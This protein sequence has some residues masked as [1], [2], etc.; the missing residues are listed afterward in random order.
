[1]TDSPSFNA[2][3]ISVSESEFYALF[4]DKVASQ[5][6]KLLT[7]TPKSN[8]DLL[9]NYLPSKLWRL[10]NLY[11]I[12]N[13]DGQHRKFHMNRAQFVV[14]SKL[15]LHH[16][17]IILKSRQQGISTL[18]LISFEDD[19]I[20]RSNLNCGL[21]AQGREEAQTLL[22]RVK[23]TWD[24]L[25]PGIK[26][27]V[28]VKLDKDNASEFS[29]SNNST[30]FIRTSFRSATL[31]RLHISELGKIANESPKKAKETKTGTLQTLAP[32]NLG[33]IESTA[34]GNNMFK[35][36]WDGAEK[37]LAVGRLA[38]KDFYPIF[39][40]WLDD[41]DCVEYEDQIPTSD[42]FD[43]FEKL[44]KDLS[45]VVT[46][47]QR[48]FWIAQER[49]LEGDIHQEYPATAKEAFAAAK[50]GT[51]WARLYLSHVIR[52][53]KKLPNIYD[54]NLPVYCVMDLGRNDL[55]V[56][57]FFQLWESIEGDISI[58]IIKSYWNSGEGLDHY[59]DKLFEFKAE[60]N[61]SMPAPIGLPHDASVTDLST[62]GQRSR[63]D[64]LHEYGVTNTVI[65]A[66]QPKEAGIEDVRKEIPY[67]ILDDR[68]TYIEDCFLNYTKVWNEELAIWRN[69]A[70]R[71]QY[72]HGADT[73]RYMVQYI[74][75]YLRGQ[76]RKSRR[77]KR[78][79]G[80]AL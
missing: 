22:E 39:L 80:V 21:M 59:A 66:K 56:L 23:Y 65:L 63:E 62:E 35:H 27:F 12:V 43:Y 9:Y 11:K 4:P 67:M 50:D 64:I 18:W 47:E 44:E 38:G 79:S 2:S 37:Q 58:R 42:Q 52:K 36:M 72:A 15:Y 13:K 45:R 54:L 24:E 5:V 25:N 14:Y 53:G 8:Q 10:N 31:H 6:W 17:L 57:L 60:Y 32:G 77:T 68:C 46:Q 33:I 75:E 20:F 74:N 48:N 30:I 61:W 69:E 26:E 1:M 28:G 70:R 49:E 73:V 3:S 51:Y 19:A 34:E 7:T 71:D 78:T 76:T 40:S 55:M 29:F 41:P 16:R